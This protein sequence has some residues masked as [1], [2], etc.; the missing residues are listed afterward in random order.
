[1]THRTAAICGALAALIVLTVAT[2]AHNAASGWQ[3]PMEC[4]HDRDCAA[5]A[6]SDVTEMPDHF[7]LMNTGETVPR[8][9][10]RRSGDGGY[11]ICRDP[12]GKILCFFYPP[13]SM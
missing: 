6:D 8:I 9:V 10:A 12:S 11:H 1:M 13:K 2:L 3:Y 5:L 4:C 7:A